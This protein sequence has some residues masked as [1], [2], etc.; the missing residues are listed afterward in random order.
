MN[1]AKHTAAVTLASGPVHK[2]QYDDD[3]AEDIAAED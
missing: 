3:D 2:S 1:H